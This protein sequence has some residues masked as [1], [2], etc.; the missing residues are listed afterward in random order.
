MKLTKLG[1]IFLT[2]ISFA[3]IANAFMLWQIYTDYQRASQ[4]ERLRFESLNLTYIIEKDVSQLSWFVKTYTSTGDF[5]YLKYYYDLRDMMTGKKARPDGYSSSYWAEVIAG[6]RRYQLSTGSGKS[7]TDL[8]KENDFSVSEQSLFQQMLKHIEQMSLIEQIAFAS[9]QGLYDP[10]NKIFIDDGEPNLVYAAQLLNEQEYLSL[11]ADLLKSV[12]AITEAVNTR[13]MNSV[14]KANQDIKQSIFYAFLMLVISITFMMI[15]VLL[16]R[17]YLLK[18]IL[19]LVDVAQSFGGG[20]YQTRIISAHA[21]KELRDLHNTFNEMAENIEQDIV[22]RTLLMKELDDAK[23][24][25]E[26]IYSH[27]QSSIEYASLIQT[28]LLPDNNLFQQCFSESF[29]YWK[30]KDTVGGDI[31]SLIQ[32]REDEYLLLVI[33]CT[34][35]GVPGAFVTMLVKAVEQQILTK[36]SSDDSD[37]SPGKILSWFNSILKYLLKQDQ[38]DVNHNAGFDGAVVYY[39]KKTSVLKFSGAE[40]DLFMMTDDGAIKIIKGSRQSVGYKKS[41]S[42]FVFADHHLS[43]EQS[44]TYYITTDGFLDQIGGEKGFS[45]GKR[46]F[47]QLLGEIKHKAFHEQSHLLDEALLAYQGSLERNDDVT[48]VAFRCEQPSIS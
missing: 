9:T 37:I 48:V 4:A 40:T 41:S 22:K 13:N 24:S 7:L 46:R 31:Y 45:F 11:N 44:M 43:C 17:R 27:T 19:E 5:K 3:L 34:G 33:D 42:D 2:G 39:N 1:S 20:E 26:N 18:P 35:H 14:N 38:P 12:L 8:L 30:P 47:Q 21:V 28:A 32:L 10:I 23:K 36:L 29:C 15:I 6:Y 25:I 16:V